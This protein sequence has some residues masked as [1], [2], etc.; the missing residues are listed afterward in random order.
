MY[1]YAICFFGQR[2]NLNFLSGRRQCNLVDICTL[3]AD[4]SYINY[5]LTFSIHWKTNSSFVCCMQL[6]YMCEDELL[7]SMITV[8]AGRIG[9]G[10][11]DAVLDVLCKY[12]V[13]CQKVCIQYS[14]ELKNNTGTSV[15]TAPTLCA[16]MC[17]YLHSILHKSNLARFEQSFSSLALP[18]T[19]EGT[20]R[21]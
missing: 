5:L 13:I 18:A 14:F 7:Y 17:G 15:L 19:N 20:K 10:A 3:W 1:K 8:I 12:I 21:L 11:E 4:S 6:N 2:W 16:D 9:R